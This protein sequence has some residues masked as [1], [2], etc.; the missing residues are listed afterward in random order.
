[1][2]IEKKLVRS[3]SNSL[4][5]RSLVLA[6]LLTLVSTAAHSSLIGKVIPPVPNECQSRESAMLGPSHQ[7]AYSFLICEGEYVVLLQKFV[8]RRE[9]KAYWVV[10]DELRIPNHGSGQEPLGVPFCQHNEHKGEYV[11]AL[12]VWKESVNSYEAVDILNAWRFN[13]ESGKIETINPKGMS[14]SLD[15][16]D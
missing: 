10:L 16:V 9:K 15:K 5:N 1:M 2:F 7:F 4:A 13:L 12:G 11:F 6:V 3:K 14:C 8:D